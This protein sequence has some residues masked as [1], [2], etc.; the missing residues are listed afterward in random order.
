MVGW[1][2]MGTF[3]DPCIRWSYW[4][5]RFSRA[6]FSTW[7]DHSRSILGELE[8]QSS[9]GQPGDRDRAQEKGHSTT[10][11]GQILLH[12]LGDQPMLAMLPY[13]WKVLHTPKTY[14][15]SSSLGCLSKVILYILIYTYIYT[16][17]YIYIIFCLAT[18]SMSWL[19]VCNT[20]LFTRVDARRCDTTTLRLGSC[21]R[22]ISSI[23]HG[24]SK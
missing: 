24:F 15:D 5:C 9:H 7:V 12:I 18:M 8:L 11:S 3:N 4:N 13:V 17:I 14:E 20:T 1:C 6:S 10:N 21:N 2:S 22:C 16:Y 23:P 19:N